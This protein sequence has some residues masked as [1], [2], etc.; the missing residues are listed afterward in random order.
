MAAPGE[1]D[2]L[3]ACR[4]RETSEERGATDKFLNHTKK[5]RGT[6]SRT[7]TLFQ[8]SFSSLSSEYRELFLENGLVRCPARGCP[9][10][11]SGESLWG[12]LKTPGLCESGGLAGIC[13]KCKDQAQDFMALALVYR[14]GDLV[15]LCGTVCRKETTAARKK[16]GRLS[17]QKGEN[18]LF[19]PGRAVSVPMMAPKRP[20]RVAKVTA[21][22]SLKNV[23][24]M[25]TDE[26]DD[27]EGKFNEFEP[28]AAGL[29]SEE[30]ACRRFR[31]LPGNRATCPASNCGQEMLRRRLLIHMDESDICKAEIASFPVLHRSIVAVYYTAMKEFENKKQKILKMESEDKE[32]L[33]EKASRSGL[34]TG[35]H[36]KEI[37]KS[38]DSCQRARNSESFEGKLS[39][40]IWETPEEF[41][42]AHKGS[43][44][45]NARGIE[46]V[47][48]ERDEVSPAGCRKT[49]SEVQTRCATNEAAN[50]SGRAA[51]SSRRRVRFADE[52]LH[53]PGAQREYEHGEKG[54][55]YN[56]TDDGPGDIRLPN[57]KSWRSK[58]NRA[59]SKIHGD[60]ENFKVRT[61][62]PS[63]EPKNI[64]VYESSATGEAMDSDPI[65]IS[66]PENSPLQPEEV[67]RSDAQDKIRESSG[68]FQVFESSSE[69]WAC[70]VP[71]CEWQGNFRN[72]PLHVYSSSCQPQE[73]LSI[74]E[75]TCVEERVIES[76]EMRL[77]FSSMVVRNE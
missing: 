7:N 27:D 60:S 76:Y 74:Q 39:R 32:K 8:Q 14:R 37:Q 56:A 28:A 63:S 61:S 13:P 46:D 6:K 71:L 41:V 55:S 58:G 68:E 20:V 21:K 11:L 48:R 2:A 64:H 43:E 54:E 36:G 35:V 65:N 42:G 22:A 52:A 19:H 3:S 12:H 47:A 29:S 38:F 18:R 33:A 50:M 73:S 59:D 9:V 31:L 67:Q 62:D 44:S 16:S 4:G 1:Y 24:K 70:P 26:S 66:V 25:L 34:E 45:A 69:V 10:Q 49:N 23:S 40:F 30:K 17:S 51:S 75:L 53:A 15:F 77:K 5:G 57:N 72:L